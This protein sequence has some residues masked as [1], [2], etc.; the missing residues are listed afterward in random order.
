MVNYHT[1][2]VGRPK[3]SEEK[4]KPTHQQ[5]IKRQGLLHGKGGS[6]DDPVDILYAQRVITEKQAEAIK[7]YKAMW[8]RAYGKNVNYYGNT[9]ASLLPDSKGF[10][11]T[12]EDL[13]IKNVN[14]YHLVDEMLKSCSKEGRRCIRVLCEGKF[15][16][17]LQSAVWAASQNFELIVELDDIEEDLKE[18]RRKKNIQNDKE[19]RKALIK[20]ID[21]VVKEKVKLEKKMKL[22]SDKEEPPFNIYAR[23]QF[24]L[25]LINLTRFFN[26]MS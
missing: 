13:K 6:I 15:P 25:A 21:E 23:D 18:L 22:Y 2:G 17:Y 10:K 3:S 14:R 11:E 24:K 12:P 9:W 20:E 7:L 26:K 8:A 1:Q 19:K 5:V 4:L 16:A